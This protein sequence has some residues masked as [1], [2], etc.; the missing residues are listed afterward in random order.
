MLAAVEK[1]RWQQNSYHPFVAG[2]SDAFLARAA[3]GGESSQGCG[4]PCTPGPV[5]VRAGWRQG[6]RVH[7][8]DV[9]VT[10]EVDASSVARARLIRGGQFVQPTPSGDST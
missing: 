7:D 3:D 9:K 1:A 8:I 2:C 10:Y 6:W 4:E 5:T